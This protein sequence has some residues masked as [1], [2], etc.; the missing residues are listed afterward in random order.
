MAREQIVLDNGTEVTTGKNGWEDEQPAYVEGWVGPP[1]YGL[2]MGDLL[3]VAEKHPEY[4]K[5][6]KDGNPVLKRQVAEDAKNAFREKYGLE[7]RSVRVAGKRAPKLSAELQ[8]TKTAMD[9]S[10]EMQAILKRD[11][12][13]LFAKLY[14]E[15]ESEDEDESDDEESETEE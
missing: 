12:P 9:S 11:N 10:P 2:T 5:D 1:H 13:E 6:Y 3:E 8:A 4:V 15:D 7:I 14:P